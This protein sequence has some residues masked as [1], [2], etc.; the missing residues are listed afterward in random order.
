[1][2]ADSEAVCP[3]LAAVSISRKTSTS[4]LEVKMLWAAKIGNTR[5]HVRAIYTRLMG[6]RPGDLL[7]RE[8]GR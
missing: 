4:A 1:M 6:S 7:P 5:R 3:Q 2:R 8:S